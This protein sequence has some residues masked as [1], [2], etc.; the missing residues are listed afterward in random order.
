MK[1]AQK[2]VIGYVRARLNMLSVISPVRAA[3]KAYEIFCTPRRRSTKPFPPIF[4]K[5]EKLHFEQQGKK[6]RGFRWNKGADRRLLILHGYESSCRKFDHHIS[7]G[8]KH[9]YEVIAFDAPAHGSSDGK[10]IT[11]LDYVEMII[12]IE[13]HYGK[14]DSYLCH[15]FGGLALVMHLEKRSHDDGTRAV[16]IA[17]ASETV[18]AVDGFFRFLKL[19]H[20]V[21]K[22]FEQ[23]IHRKSGFWPSHFSAS[24]ALKNVKASILWIH[25]EDDLITPLKDARKIQDLGFPN[26]EFMITKGLGHN[27][28]YRDVEVK[29]KIFSFLSHPD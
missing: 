6:V 15:S 27:K 26:I 2:I 14:V 8:I 23:I 10:Q 13:K 21:R 12:N 24:R 3:E 17:P 11:L 16:L 29:R 22:A 9:G 28:I 5:S 20:Q 25:D 7:R 19:N 1:L 4:S 18:T